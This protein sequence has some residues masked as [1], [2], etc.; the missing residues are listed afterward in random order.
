MRTVFFGSPGTGKTAQLTSLFDEIRDKGVPLDD[1]C[2][3]TYTRPAA[4]EFR[5]RIGITQK[6]A[7]YIGTLHSIC[8]HALSE[9]TLVIPRNMMDFCE[10]HGIPTTIDVQEEDTGFF[11]IR[12]YTQGEFLFSALDWARHICPD[13]PKSHLYDAPSAVYLDDFLRSNLE[14][15]YDLWEKFK[16]QY[17]LVDFT[18]LLLQ[19]Y[20]ENYTPPT[21]ILFA[22]EFQDF[23]YLQYQLYSIFASASKDV[24]IAG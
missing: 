5:E 21:K 10:L 3:I 6:E 11:E 14:K 22:D 9:P 18:D 2:F 8:F 4:I 12:N 19:C 13:N 16:A 17:R 24:Y 1:I 7:H 15:Y 23:T 20:F